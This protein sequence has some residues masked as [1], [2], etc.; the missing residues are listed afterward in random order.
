[1]DASSGK[2]QVISIVVHVEKLFEVHHS[3]ILQHSNVED[4]EMIWM[5][6][7]SHYLDEDD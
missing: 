7:L 3:S 2:H 1:M 6:T 5:S 4:V